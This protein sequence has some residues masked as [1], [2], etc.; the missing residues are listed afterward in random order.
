[1]PK[2]PPSS[3]QI[4]LRPRLNSH[5]HAHWPQLTGMT[6]RHR[7]GLAYVAG[8]LPGETPLPPRRLRFTGAPHTWGL[9]PQVAGRDGREDGTLPSGPPKESPEEALDCA[10]ALY[11]DPIGPLLPVPSTR[12][13]R[14]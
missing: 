6:V 12:V 3:M 10:C 9:S 1:M 4:S 11:L 14:S 5:A 13:P 8:G 2:S 7:T